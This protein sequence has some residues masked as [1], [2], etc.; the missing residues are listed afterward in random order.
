MKQD[1]MIKEFWAILAVGVLLVVFMTTGI[2]LWAGI[3]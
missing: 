2:Y 1:R 3:R